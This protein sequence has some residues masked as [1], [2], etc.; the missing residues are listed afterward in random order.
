VTHDILNKTDFFFK[1]NSA[2]LDL[3]QVF[4]DIRLYRLPSDEL[5]SEARFLSLSA[6]ISKQLYNTRFTRIK[7]GVIF[8]TTYLSDLFKLATKNVCLS[9]T[10]QFDFITT[11]R[12]QNP[13]D[14]ALSSYLIDFLRLSGK[15]TLPY[16]GITSYIALA[17]LID[18]YPLGIYYL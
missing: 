7:N 6:N 4:S 17:I 8:S 3:L 14:R 1:L 9:P 2:Y 10:N 11:I 16:K 5:S 12:Q 13:L 15:A 18:A